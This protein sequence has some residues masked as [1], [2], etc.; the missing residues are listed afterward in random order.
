MDMT[1]IMVAMMRQPD[2]VRVVLEKCT[3]FLVE[4]SKAIK[5]AGANGLV[6][7]EPAAGLLSPKLCDKFSSYYVKQIV[8]AVQ[9]DNFMVILHNCGNTVKL[10]DSMVS[11]GAAGLHFGNSVAMS[12]II[13]QVPDDRM[14]LGNI[15][16]AG[17][18]RIGTVE[19]MTKQVESL[20]TAMR[21][22]KNFVLSSG[23]DIPPGTPLANVTAFFMALEQYNNRK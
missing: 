17:T 5:N 11:T 21:G 16:P 3:S 10:V 22:Y 18:F 20:L 23:C 12:D 8:D 14:V 19:Q 4:Y 15:N 9:D 7:A 6:I 2:T 13:P 1:A